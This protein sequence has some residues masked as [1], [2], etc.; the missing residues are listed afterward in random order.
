MLNNWIDTTLP[1][2]IYQAATDEAEPVP[3]PIGYAGT[4]VQLTGHTAVRWK[5]TCTQCHHVLWSESGEDPRV[6]EA[7]TLRWRYQHQHPGSDRRLYVPPDQ[8]P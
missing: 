5:L 3:E 7:R 8:R 4:C 2:V 6:F 1:P